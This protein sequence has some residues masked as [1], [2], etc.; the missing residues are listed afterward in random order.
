MCSSGG[1]PL[2]YSSVLSIK[3]KQQQQA[4]VDKGNNTINFLTDF[5]SSFQQVY[6]KGE[7]S[8]SLYDGKN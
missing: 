7:K 1:I 6:M 5:S 2:D 8:A 3:S 4:P